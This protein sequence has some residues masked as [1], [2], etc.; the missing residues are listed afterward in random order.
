MA[1]VLSLNVM[2]T[3][4][5]LPG[6]YL[7]ICLGTNLAVGPL[8][9]DSSLKSGRLVG[10]DDFELFLAGGGIDSH[11]IANR[12]ADDRCADG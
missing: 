2:E 5:G 10:L 9:A 7:G 12:A 4:W 3:C 11:C 6:T 1:S 8:Q